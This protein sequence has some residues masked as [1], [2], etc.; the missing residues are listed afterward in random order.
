[1]Y[2]SAA[3]TAIPMQAECLGVPLVRREILGKAMLQSLNYEVTEND[4]VEDLFQLLKDVKV[5][6]N[7]FDR[8]V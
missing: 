8:F 7:Y 5:G 2:Q 1:M 3:F 4:E 6:V